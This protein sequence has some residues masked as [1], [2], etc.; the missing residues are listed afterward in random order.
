MH[1][2]PLAYLIT[3]RT[4]GT[5][6]PGDGRGAFHHA[7]FLQP[8]APL[9]SEARE[10]FASEP[11]V[12]FPHARR[13]VEWAI[14][15]ACEHKGWTLHALN[16]RT[17]HVHLVAAMLA[18]PERGMGTV[19]A[20]ATRRL[21]EHGITAHDERAWSRHGSTRYLW[22]EAEVERAVRYVVEWQG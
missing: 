1:N 3:F 5:W 13:V 18:P 12:L 6:P 15:E 14:R 16:V 7:R 10:R 8:S 2:P 4:Y 19:K 21:R 11:F 9:R 20:W 17:N 22:S